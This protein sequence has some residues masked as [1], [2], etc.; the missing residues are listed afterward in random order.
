MEQ[1][2]EV[3]DILKRIKKYRYLSGLTQENMADMLNM[4]QNAYYK[5]E[6]GKTK[7]LVSSLLAIAETLEVSPEILLN[8]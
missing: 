2:K 1:N 3:A 5:I 6:A 7:L 4:S 8:E